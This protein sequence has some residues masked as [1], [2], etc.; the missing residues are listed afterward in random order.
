[1]PKNKETTTTAKTIYGERVFCSVCKELVFIWHRVT[2]FLNGACNHLGETL[3]QKGWGKKDGRMV[4]PLCHTKAFS[5]HE[6]W[7]P[8][9]KQAVATGE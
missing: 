4:C 2:C 7:Q 5:N 3:T 9:E 1:M 6:P 8:D